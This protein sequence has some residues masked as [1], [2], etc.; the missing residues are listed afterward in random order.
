V[1]ILVVLVVGVVGALAAAGVA[2]AS[3]E[4]RPERSFFGGAG[5]SLLVLVGVVAV[6]VL[7]AAAVG[8]VGLRGGG[9]G[10]DE[11]AAARP[12]DTS[13]GAPAKVPAP[14]PPEPVDEAPVLPARAGPEV[15]I[16]S[17][18]SA[19]VVDRLPDGAVLV[20]TAKGFEPGTGQ[21][22]QCG[23]AP[24]GPRG[25]VN[26]FPVEFDGDGTARFQ[27]LVSDRVAPAGRCGAGQ[28]ACLVVV[29]GSYGERGSVFTVFHGPA[30][31]P[32]LVAVEPRAGLSNGD[33]VTVRASGFPPATRLFA[34]QCPPGTEV[35]PG[36][37]RR[38]AST[39]TSPDGDAVLR[40]T[41]RTGEVDGI[42]CGPRR[43][44][45]VRVAAEAPV[46]PVTVP[47][48]FTTGP[49]ARYNGGRVAAGLALA[50]L[51]LALARR[52]VRTT[53]WR[54]PA[55]AATPEMD[56]AVLDA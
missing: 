5:P 41:L 16:T 37:C 53:D 32:G 35:D 7:G 38:A 47:V 54:E 51:L 34:A 6:V 25:C 31:P 56:R 49:S 13:P 10:H 9:G 40:L 26:R 33:V 11:P 27:Y 46:A 21:V 28:T 42:S 3:G 39:T 29:F 17:G 52:L 20:V 4:G 14:A 15:A 23:P 55:A 12:P 43:P 48:T 8:L 19:T 44:C 30:P 24:E 1:L 50:I 45:S 36:R 2:V 18:A 22:A